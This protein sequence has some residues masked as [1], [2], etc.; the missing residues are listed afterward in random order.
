M[1]VGDLVRVEGDMWST[2]TK[3]DEVGLVVRVCNGE[4]GMLVLWSDGIS[5]FGR[6]DHLEVVNES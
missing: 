4:K 2:Y 5:I 3:Q 6:P 1:K